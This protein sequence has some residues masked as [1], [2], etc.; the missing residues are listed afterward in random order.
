MVEERIIL[1]S[2]MNSFYASVEMMKN[3]KLKGKA[4]A[5]GGSAKSRHGIILA[6]SEKAKKAGIITGMANWQALELCPELIIISPHYEEYLKYSQLARNIYQ[7]YTDLVEPY[8]MDECFLDVSNSINIY[9]GGKI[10]AEEIRQTIKEELGLTV[11]IGVSYNK[12]FAKLG[13]DIKKPDAVTEITLANYKKVVWN[14]PVGELFYVGKATENKL[15]KYGITTIGKLANTPVEFLKQLLGKNGEILWSYANGSDSSR[16]M[17]KDFISPVKSIGHGITCNKDLSSEEEVWKVILELSQDIG[18]KLIVHQLK[19][20]GV[21]LSVRDNNL[22]TRQFQG[23]LPISTQ[24]PMEIGKGARR[25]FKENYRWSTDIR[26]ITVRAIDLKS[27]FEE[28]QLDLFM[29]I[30]KIKKE[31]RL[32]EAIE[33]VRRRFGKHSIHQAVLLG[34][35]KL[36]TYRDHNLVLPGNMNR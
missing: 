11:S 34:D 8:G 31:E 18:H 16:V 36:P 4:V 25:L 2:D 21:Q 33:E 13:S 30:E 15:R 24:N 9:G 32:F 19:A 7:R 29:D 3:P 12:V 22:I 28:E 23:K 14:L 27:K 20:K 26:S 17:N 5:V 6:K 10:I 1:H 35:I